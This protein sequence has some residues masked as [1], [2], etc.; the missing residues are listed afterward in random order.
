MG[1]SSSE[2]QKEFLYAEDGVTV[3]GSTFSIREQVAPEWFGMGPQSGFVG[4]GPQINPKVYCKPQAHRWLKHASHPP[5][6]EAAPQ[7][8]VFNR[9]KRSV[10]I[11]LGLGAAG[12]EL[13]PGEAIRIALP[14]QESTLYIMDAFTNTCLCDLPGLPKSPLEVLPRAVLQEVGGV[15]CAALEY[16]ALRTEPAPDPSKKQSS[17]SEQLPAPAAIAEGQ[18]QGESPSSLTIMLEQQLLDALQ[19]NNQERVQTILAQ[20]RSSK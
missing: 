17:P 10:K 15:M 6:E 4:P 11:S 13:E 20:L 8:A 3:I 7:L 1:Q 14:S 18:G 5:N 12:E 2:L 19:N 16:S 9:S